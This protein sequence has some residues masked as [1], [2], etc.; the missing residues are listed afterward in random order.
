MKQKELP[1][2]KKN[3]SRYETDFPISSSDEDVEVWGRQQVPDYAKAQQL[4]Q[5]IMGLHFFVCI[6]HNIVL[7]LFWSLKKEKSTLLLQH[8]RLEGKVN[9]MWQFMLDRQDFSFCGELWGLVI[10]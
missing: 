9:L 10:A 7:Y 1:K 4:N 6:V 8:C 2:K 3:Q 5:N